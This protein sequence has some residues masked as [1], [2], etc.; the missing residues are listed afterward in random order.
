VD[1]LAALYATAKS[2]PDPRCRTLFSRQI[3][4][5]SHKIDEYLEDYAIEKA[6]RIDKSVDP[7]V[8]SMSFMALVVHYQVLD[9]PGRKKKTVR[10]LGYDHQNIA[11]LQ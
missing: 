1:E 9:L 7:W 8:Y 3:T 5:S 4:E 11:M 2:H 10:I 6:D